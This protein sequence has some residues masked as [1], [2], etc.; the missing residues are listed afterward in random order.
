MA[1]R[2]CDV[3]TVT[4]DQTTGQAKVVETSVEEE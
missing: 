4:Q 2:R 3:P 1:R